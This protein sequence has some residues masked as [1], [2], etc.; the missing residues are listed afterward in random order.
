MKNDNEQEDAE[1]IPMKLP[2]NK[3]NNNNRNSS[4]N[5]S[6]K[7]FEKNSFFFIFI[8]LVIFV[9]IFLADNNS[10]IIELNDH[11]NGL[12]SRVQYMDK[13]IVKKKI[14]VAI[15]RQ[16][17]IGSYGR[18]I[19]VLSR[20]LIETGEFNVYLIN[21]QK[22]DYD[23]MYHKKVKREIIK[24]NLDEMRNFDEAND[25]QIYILLNDLSETIELFKSLGKKVVGIFNVEYFSCIYSNETEVYRIFKGFSKFDSFVQFVPDDYW[26][27]KKLGFNNTIYIPSLNSF[28]SEKTQTSKLVNKNILMVG[29]F[30]QGIKGG[31][32]GIYAMA[33]I[34]K[35]VPDAKLII[36]GFTFPQPLLDLLKQLKI[37]KNVDLVGF[38]QSISHF[39]LNASVLL[40]PSISDS[41]ATIINEGKAHGLPIVAFDLDYNPSFQN[42]VINVDMF[43]YSLMAKE[44][45][46]LLKDYDYRIEMGK[47]A[48]LSLKN[49]NE[50]FK[51]WRN[52]F[53]SLLNNTDTDK[54]KELQKEVEKKYYNES[55]AKN[56]LEK[57]YH[58]ALKYNSFFKCH[59]FDDFTSLDY[60]NNIKACPAK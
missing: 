17:L 8:S 20:F 57:H 24:W 10:S 4:R 42:G 26:I 38:T 16:Y 40:V 47:K 32:Y 43:N 22:T 56:R 50:S 3:T 25:I 54:Y 44:A 7:F 58:Y 48:K 21:E 2:E 51:I 36:M 12:R 52:L 35:E 14:G 41:F 19:S 28:E 37:E 23:I 45:V 6:K 13:N 49:N 60:I 29:K 11:I 39:Y 9:M 5:K 30:D 33:E 34:L 18:F 31:V 27:Y 59:S 15:V 46:K 1:E 53:K 55:I